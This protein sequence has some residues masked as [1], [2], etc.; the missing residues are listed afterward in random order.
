M[1][2]APVSSAK[3]VIV[4]GADDKRFIDQLL[5]ARGAAGVQVQ[6]IG[7][8]SQLRA[9]LQ[10]LRNDDEFPVVSSVAVLR[11]A[12][13]NP[14]AAWNSVVGALSAAGFAAPG[15]PGDFADGP[16]RVGALLLPGGGKHGSLET[17]CLASLLSAELECIDRLL[18]CVSG[19]GAP[20]PNQL[21]KAR[22]YAWLAT[23]ERPGLRVG[24]AAEKGYW[25][26]SSH[27]FDDLW[28]FLSRI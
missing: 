8:K 10:I 13:D 6:P 21:D 24:E 9:Y 27:A 12:D 23:R 2:V 5:M 20:R 11:D 26:F 14:R 7:G 19:L 3:Q 4:E 22:A 25:N 18:D 28:A 17:L 15:A 16:P 1:T